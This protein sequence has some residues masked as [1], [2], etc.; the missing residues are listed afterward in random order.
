M[1]NEA[2]ALTMVFD[3]WQ[4]HQISLVKAVERLTREQLVYRSVSGLRTVGQIVNHIACGRAG[5]LLSIGEVSTEQVGLVEAWEEGD[6]A[7]EKA[8]ELVRW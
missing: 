7:S 5:W 1:G 6:G 8:V 4:G 3:G 2:F